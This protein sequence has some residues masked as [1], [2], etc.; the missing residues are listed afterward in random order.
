MRFVSVSF[1][2]LGNDLICRFRRSLVNAQANRYAPR[3]A[4]RQCPARHIEP[5][6]GIYDNG[7]LVVLPLGGR[8]LLLR[9]MIAHK[10]QRHVADRGTG[11]SRGWEILVG[12]TAKMA[13][14][15][16]IQMRGSTSNCQSGRQSNRA[17]RIMKTTRTDLKRKRCPIAVIK[18]TVARK[19][20]MRTY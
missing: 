10:R 16:K 7:T 12:P 19:T 3:L 4:R 5:L 14:L 2:F 20:V 11:V 6:A 9:A 8:E 13:M 15:L 1:L 17:A 18:S